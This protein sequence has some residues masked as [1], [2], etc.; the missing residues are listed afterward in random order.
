[1]T[2]GPVPPYGVPIRDAIARGDLR[3]M[4]S[5][6]E[7]V[8]PALEDLG[9]A[10]KKLE[11]PNNSKGP[12]PPYGTPIRDAIARGDVQEMKATAAAARKAIYKVD[13]AQVP[14]EKR[15]DALAALEELEN[16]ITVLEKER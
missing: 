10:I 12:V 16:A 6:Y 14:P 11:E 4:K 2:K 8:K 7:S 3:E 5:L 1:M 15:D 13:F 9:S